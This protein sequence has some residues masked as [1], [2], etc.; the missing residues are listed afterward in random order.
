MLA[1]GFERLSGK[2]RYK[3]FPSAGTIAANRAAQFDESGEVAIGATNKHN[4]GVAVAAATSA[5]N[6]VLD[7]IDPNSVWRAYTFTGT[8]S[9]ALIGTQVDIGAGL[10]VTLGT[11]THN[12]CTV[13]GGDVAGQAYVDITFGSGGLTRSEVGDE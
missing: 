12:D 1:S 13:I 10:T 11:T 9:A 6:A 4:V 3:I 2:S 5:T 7:I 8:Y